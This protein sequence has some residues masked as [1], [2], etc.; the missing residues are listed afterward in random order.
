MSKSLFLNIWYKCNYDCVYCVIWWIQDEFK[1]EDFVSLEKIK[2]ID[3]SNYS[4]VWLTW[5]EPTIHPNFFEILDYFHENWLEIFMQTNGSMLWVDEFFRKIKKYNIEYQLPLNSFNEKIHNVIMKHKNAYNLTLWGIKNILN[6]WRGD[7][8]TV[9]IILTKL[10][11]NHIWKTVSFLC[12]LGVKKFYIAYPVI[13]WNLLKYVDKLVPKYS[14]IKSFLDELIEI[15]EKECI[16]YVLESFPYCVLDEK[17]YKNVWEIGQLSYDEIENI[18]EE[19]LKDY[20]RISESCFKKYGFRWEK[21]N[22]ANCKIIKLKKRLNNVSFL[23]KD[24]DKEIN[25]NCLDNVHKIKKESCLKCKY[26]IICSGVSKEYA[27]KYWTS[28]FDY[29]KIKKSLSKADVLK[30]IKYIDEI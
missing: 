30:Y 27:K 29:K 9:K 23:H 7:N 4:S 16:R 22:C 25:A 14:E 8:L 12:S 26:N 18:S 2:S 15:E 19:D 21:S 13:K 5:W 6:D 28:E 24:L 10:N 17:L 20:L 11:Y 3:L 1:S